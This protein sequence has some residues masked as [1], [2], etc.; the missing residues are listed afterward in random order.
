MAKAKLVFESPGTFLSFPALSPF[1]FRPQDLDFSRAMADPA[2]GAALQDFSR[3]VS[4]CPGNPIFDIGSD[5]YLWDHYSAWLNAMT[6]AESNLS[7]GDQ[8]AYAAARALLVV[9]DA[10]GLDSDSPV[11]VAYKQ[12]RD[13]VLNAEQAYKAAQLTATAAGDAA[14]ANWQNTDEPKLRAAVAAAETAW[15]TTGR[16]ADVEAAQA[17]VARCEAA[18][19]EKMWAS[20]RR[21]YNPDLDNVTD[22]ASNSSYAPSGF[23][24]AN[25]VSDDWTTLRVSGSEIAALTAAMPKTLLEAFGEAGSSQFSQISFEFRSAS[26]VQPWFNPAIFKARFW[27]FADGSAL[28]DGGSPPSGAWPAYVVAVVFVRN[29]KVTPQ[30]PP[31]PP[32]P[33][34][35]MPKLELSPA[36]LERLQ[37][38]RAWGG[39]PEHSASAPPSSVHATHP[40]ALQTSSFAHSPQPV[41]PAPVFALSPFALQR[42][43]AEH[44]GSP[45][46]QPSFVPRPQIIA[47]QPPS[48]VVTSALRRAPVATAPQLRLVTATYRMSTS[49][50][51][52]EVAVPPISASPISASPSST[53]TAAAS[54]PP[55][56]SAPPDDRISILAFICKLLPKT[57]DP[58]PSLNW[59]GKA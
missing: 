25:L 45:T 4:R 11:V 24:P 26:V 39:P 3:A 47:E 19:P 35:A 17:L 16:Q 27:K 51:H 1:S 44:A 18:M 15:A 54:P 46:Q 32:V 20:W 31:Q 9:T 55:A 48:P 13:A 42:L 21:A 2:I 5:E 8:A 30:G 37:A 33:I 36:V 29:I 49:F 43:Q 38:Q 56:A 58:N 52:P 12:C 7:P 34:R 59:S 23:S 22:P 10:N 41:R 50:A 40:P 14:L 28:N 6:L 53:S 57:P